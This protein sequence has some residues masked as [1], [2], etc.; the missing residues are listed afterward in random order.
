MLKNEMKYPTCQ[1]TALLSPVVALY[2]FLGIISPLRAQDWAKT[3]IKELQR[4]DLR[5]LGYPF[6]NEIPENSSAITSLLTAR[7]GKIYGG[8][9][10]EESFLFL[11]DPTI[12]KVRHLGKIPEQESVHHALAEDIDGFIYLGTGRNMFEEIS[13]S[14]GGIGTEGRIDK[15]LWE[16][17]KNHFKEYPGGHLYRYNPKSDNQKVKLP[18]MSCELEDLGIPLANNSIY[19]LTINPEGNEIYV[20]TYPDGHFFVYNIEMKKFTDLGP[21]DERIVFHG[22]ERYWRSLPRSLVCDHSGKVFFSGTE[23]I[24][25]YYDPVTRK[26]ISTDIR[27]PGDYY[28]LQFFE[29]YAVVDYFT[30]DPNGLI[31][32]GTSD[33]YLFSF[34]PAGMKLKNLGKMRA[35]RRLRCLSVGFDGKVYIMA[36]ER[37]SSR[38]CQFYSYDPR[39]G[40]YDDLGLLI[41]DRSPYYYW[42]GQQFDAMTTGKDGTLYIGESER[43]SHLFLYIP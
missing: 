25:R 10:G 42:R 1:K 14:K 26:L 22:P 39:T 13:L 24:I 8:T 28:Y 6:V 9:T 17:I 15:S 2:L 5:D 3:N 41:V 23:G 21:V 31:Y 11:F 29:D 40:G 37:S 30:T 34:D 12:N 43:R 33:G 20:I 16:D 38:P 35:S 18:V 32:G 27:I 19:A 4:V 7:D 36:G